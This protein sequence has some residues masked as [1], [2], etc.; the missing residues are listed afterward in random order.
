MPLSRQSPSSSAGSVAGSTSGLD[1]VVGLDDEVSKYTNKST[2]GES[3][4]VAAVVTEDLLEAEEA[5]KPSRAKTTQG[6]RGSNSFPRT[7]KE[8]KEMAASAD[9]RR[10]NGGPRSRLNPRRG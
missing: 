6:S 4:A 5:I 3:V 2:F 1:T 7:V 8:R 9:V 10:K